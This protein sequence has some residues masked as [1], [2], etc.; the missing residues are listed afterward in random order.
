M[1]KDPNHITTDE[2]LCNLNEEQNVTNRNQHQILFLKK[3]NGDK[4]LRLKRLSIR[5]TPIKQTKTHK[6]KIYRKKTPKC[7][8]LESNQYN[9]GKTIKKNTV[10]NKKIIINIPVSLIYHLS[11]FAN[12][13]KNLKTTVSTS[14]SINHLINLSINIQEKLHICNSPQINE[15]SVSSLH[16]L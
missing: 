6:K 16:E 14:F 5:L 12:L 7:R 15:I 4:K 3:I 13:S 8:S 1:S 9:I 10:S 11:K 2:R